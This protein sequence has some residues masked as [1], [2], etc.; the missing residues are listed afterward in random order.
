MQRHHRQRHR[1]MWL[2]LTPIL[3][4]AFYLA[5]TTRPQPVTNDSVPQPVATPLNP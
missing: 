4:G 3:I 1:F 2:I 5:L